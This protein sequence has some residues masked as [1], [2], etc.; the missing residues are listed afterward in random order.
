MAKLTPKQIADSHIQ[1][2]R[3]GHKPLSK[4]VQ[5]ELRGTCCRDD[6]KV[7]FD[8]LPHRM[9]FDNSLTHEN[10][11]GANQ[12]WGFTNPD[13]RRALVKAFNDYKAATTVGLFAPPTYALITHIGFNVSR[14]PE[15]MT[16][17]LTSR[18]GT[19][20]GVT[21]TVHKV[22]VGGLPCAPTR[23]YEKSDGQTVTDVVFEAPQAGNLHQDYVLV[24]DTPLF[25]PQAEEI[26]LAVGNFAT[27]D[28][29]T[30]AQFDFTVAINYDF[31]VRATD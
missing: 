15:G 14:L 24:L 18:N 31:V 27:A 19:L 26:S 23:D 8:R 2:F 20:D 16:L 7:K 6:V 25:V 4:A 21:A 22:V 17:K 12:K 29:V 3:G 30:E 5:A 1:V 13:D 28:M 9:R 10:P 11:N